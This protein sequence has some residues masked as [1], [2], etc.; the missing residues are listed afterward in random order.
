MEAGSG[1]SESI[2]V[3]FGSAAPQATANA[4]SPAES[5]VQ[6]FILNGFTG[7][8]L[9]EPKV[10]PDD[11]I[12]PRIDRV[13]AAVSDSCQGPYSLLVNANPIA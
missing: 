10:T 2:C 1:S 13:H 9:L 6:R 4:N 8:P 11:W 5:A 7:Q 3:A 12:T